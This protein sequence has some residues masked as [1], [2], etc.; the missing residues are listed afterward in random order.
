MMEEMNIVTKSYKHK[1]KYQID[2]VITTDVSGTVTTDVWIGHID[3]A[4]KLHMFGL[5]NKTLDEVMEI[6][7]EELEDDDMYTE[8]IDKANVYQK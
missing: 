4:L 5:R 8:C 1:D 2:L 3:G 6:V 7:E